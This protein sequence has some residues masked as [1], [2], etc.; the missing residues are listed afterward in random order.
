MKTYPKNVLNV[1]KIE[2]LT[3]PYNNVYKF[4]PLVLMRQIPQ[5]N[6]LLDYRTV[7]YFYFSLQVFFNHKIEILTK[8][9]F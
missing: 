7:K 2:S 9:L 8:L 4:I 1:S 5:P 6:K 3:Y